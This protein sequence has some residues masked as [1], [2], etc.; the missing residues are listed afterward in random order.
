MYLRSGFEEVRRVQWN[1][2][3]APLDW[4][5]AALENFSEGRP[6]VVSMVG[7]PID[8]AFEVVPW[9]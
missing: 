8:P 7:G 6:D 4:D 3:L 2:E 1:N 9:P 5:Y